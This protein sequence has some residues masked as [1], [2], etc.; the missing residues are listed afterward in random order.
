MKRNLH[1]LISV[2]AL[3]VIL[4]MTATGCRMSNDPVG[5]FIPLGSSGSDGGVV[6]SRATF[7]T[8]LE[9]PSSLNRIVH[10]FLP[11]LLAAAPEFEMKSVASAPD[12]SLEI[13]TVRSGVVDFTSLEDVSV[14][15]CG[16]SGHSHCQKAVIRAYMSAS[17]P[18]QVK[19]IAGL[20][21]NILSTLGTGPSQ[22]AVLQ[23]VLIPA[24]S[25]SVK[26]A[27]FTPA[28]EYEIKA[29]LSKA[30][31]GTYAATIVLEY[32]LF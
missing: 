1:F 19:I 11:R 14:D 15:V 17:V 26:L 9:K 12:A 28:P 27:D 10:F 32:V 24:K 16:Q 3:P 21:T 31:A 6:K 20:S 23:T 5:V 13:G 25:H 2:A 7:E 8:S 22:A 29:D 4:A 30:R 18:G